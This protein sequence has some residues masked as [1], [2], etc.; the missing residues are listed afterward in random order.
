MALDAMLG[1]VVAAV[2]TIVD[3]DLVAECWG[4]GCDNEGWRQGWGA[5]GGIQV[6][7]LRFVG[8]STMLF[9]AWQSVHRVMAVICVLDETLAVISE[10]AVVGIAAIVGS[11]VAEGHQGSGLRT[12]AGGFAGV[13]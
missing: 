10:V 5:V 9:R 4:S 3:S 1:M 7:V 13:L 8:C 12:G 6:F 2:G 11:N